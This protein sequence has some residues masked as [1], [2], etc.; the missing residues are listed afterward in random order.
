MTLNKSRENSIYQSLRLKMR[1]PILVEATYY[2]PGGRYLLVFP[3]KLM[4]PA[5]VQLQVNKIMS[6]TL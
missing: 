5:P 3:V 6:T 1:E 4:K 2:G